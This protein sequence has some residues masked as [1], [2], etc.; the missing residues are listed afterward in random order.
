MLFNKIANRK[1]KANVENGC[2]ERYY[3]PY[4]SNLQVQKVL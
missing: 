2:K 3:S 1:W 4:K